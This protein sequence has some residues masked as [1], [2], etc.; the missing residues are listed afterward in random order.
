MNDWGEFPEVAVRREA[1]RRQ[2]LS[3]AGSLLVST[4]FATVLFGGKCLAAGQLR[5]GL[6]CSAAAIVVRCVWQLWRL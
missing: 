5:V 2:R 4:V 1:A 6:A 3:E